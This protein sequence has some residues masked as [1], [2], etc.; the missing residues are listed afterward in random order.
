MT[1]APILSYPNPNAWYQLYT[2]ASHKGLRAVLGQKDS[3]GRNRVIAYA[4]TSLNSGKQHYAPVHLECRG[5]VWAIRQFHHYLHGQEFDVYTDQE[6]LKSLLKQ[7]PDALANRTMGRWIHE[8]QQ[9][10]FT[11]H[12]H[13]GPKNCTDFLS[14]AL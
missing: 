2:D 14:R 3:Q 10:H 7:G 5:V 9:H 1:E 4:S 6:A 8:L 13:P 12:Y 11:V